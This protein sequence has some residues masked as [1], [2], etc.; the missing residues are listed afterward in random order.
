MGWTSVFI[1]E[2]VCTRISTP[3]LVSLGAEG[4]FYTSGTF[5][6]AHDS[7]P[8]YHGVWHIFVLLGS[9]AH[10]LAILFILS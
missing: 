1:A 3:A 10:W 4:V 2:P 7:R 9:V 5:F 8:Y 6:F